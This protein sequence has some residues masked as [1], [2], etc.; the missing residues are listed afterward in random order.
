MGQKIHPRGFRTG[1]LYDWLST[2]YANKFQYRHFLAADLQ[3]RGFLKKRL[4]LAGVTDIEIKRS[5]GSIDIFLHVSRP[6]VVIGRGGSNLELLKNELMRLV[7]KDRRGMAP[8][9]VN[10]HPVEVKYPDLSAQ[11]VA[12]RIAQQIEKR[13]PHRRAKDQA[14]ERVMGSGAKGVKIKF[15]GR[16]GGAEIHRTEK[17]A[18]GKIPTQTLRADIDYAHVPALTRSG[19]VGVTVWIYKGE[20]VVK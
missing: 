14:I 16:I 12:E 10:L 2:W 15:S 18:R 19:Y 8:L 11:L 20:K 13:Y 6:G 4:E 1:I 5:I 17:Y 7:N 3:L 9:N